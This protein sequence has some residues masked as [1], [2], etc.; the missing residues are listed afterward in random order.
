MILADAGF[1]YALADADDAWHSRA[2]QALATQAEGWIT[3]WPVLTEATHLLTRWIGADAAQALLRDVAAGGIAVWQWAAPQTERLAL[4]MERYA[5]LPMDLADASLV[6]LAEHLGHG[7]I[8]TTDERDFGAY[9]FK[10]REPFQN[11][12]SEGAHG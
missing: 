5:S 11:L 2:R 9:R 4:L 8:L 10:S 3:T 6:L 7:R 12:L 1:F